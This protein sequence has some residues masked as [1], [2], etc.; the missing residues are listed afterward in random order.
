MHDLSAI[1]EDVIGG[2]WSML[3]SIQIPDLVTVRQG[4]KD[5]L[6]DLFHVD[7]HWEYPDTFI[8]SRPMFDTTLCQIDQ[9]ESALSAALYRPCEDMLSDDRSSHVLRVCM[10]SVGGARDR[11]AQAVSSIRQRFPN[12]HFHGDWSYL[13]N[14]YGYAD[15]ACT[16]P[17]R[18][19]N[20][21]T[22]IIYHTYA[23]RLVVERYDE[24]S[25]DVITEEVHQVSVPM[26]A[27]HPD[28]HFI[29]Y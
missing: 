21:S 2:D 11:L 1:L 4:G 12:L 26:V 27:G 7:K 23:R 25:R 20:I 22:D 28:A 29:N 10:S 8:I 16:Y 5:N 13:T 18:L 6:L 19:F 24:V 17:V 9:E 14:I 15:S 3:S